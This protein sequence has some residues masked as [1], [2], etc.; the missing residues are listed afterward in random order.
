MTPM[1][2]LI[3]ALT[4]TLQTPAGWD[5][6]LQ[7]AQQFILDDRFAD[8]IAILEGVLKSSPNFD[9]ARYELADA[10]RMLA[11][12]AAIKGDAQEATKRR[13]FERAAAEYRRVAEGASD[14]KPLAV[15]KL[16]MVYGKDE[17]DRPA[18]LVPFARQYIQFSPGSAVGHAS[19]ANAL[20]ASGQEAAATAALLAARQAVGTDDAKLL[21]TVIVEHV[22]N[23][24][25]SSASDLTALLDWADA[26]LDRLLRDAPTD[27]GLLLTKAASASL[28]AD[29]LATDPERKRALKVEADRAFKR[30]QDA[31][32]DRLPTSPDA[33]PGALPPVPPPPPPPPPMPPGFE[34]AM[35]DA[36][37]LL[38]AKRFAEAASVWDRLIASNPDFP[39]PHYLRANAL[40]LAGQRPAVEAALKKARISIADAAVSRHMAV[41]YLFDMVTSNKTIAAAD[42]KL[43]LAEARFMS[44][45][46]LQANPTYW[47]AATYRALVVS[48]QAKFET[49]PAVIEKL[50]AEAARLRKE[51]EALRPK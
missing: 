36:D 42:A 23:T 43:L 40:L 50:T 8:A 29:R 12:Q 3:I 48:M 37:K 11:L 24:K 28:R 35:A 7:R 13:A 51:A 47:E 16:M 31:N 39:P 21:A 10:H 32:P 33:S 26:T 5:A 49:D 9:P 1:R 18:D 46:A 17:L 4:L 27:R 38:V 19:L 41:T 20:T 44:D 34:Q 30:F 14:Y 2:F 15:M 6:T 25:T 22:Q 45:A